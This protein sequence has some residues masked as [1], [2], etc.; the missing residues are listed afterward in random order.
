MKIDM[1]FDTAN[2]EK[3]FELSAKQIAYASV[4]AINRT[5]KELQKE[6]QANARNRLHLRGGS[7]EQL[8]LRSVAKIFQFASV[9]KG[10]PYAEI[11]IDTGKRL[12]L[13]GLELGGSK[14]PF[15]GS[16]VAVPLTG[17]AARPSMGASVPGNLHISN[18][19]L[20]PPLTAAQ[21]KQRQSIKGTNAK[22]TRSM[23]AQFTR[24]QGAGSVWKGRDRTFMIDRGGDTKGIFQRTGP[25][26][27]DFRLI[28]K[29][30]P[31]PALKPMLGF[32]K[33]AITDGDPRLARNLED[34]VR[35]A[36]IHNA[37]KG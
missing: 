12:V 22:E 23:R 13:T 29:F 1:K 26:K 7:G 25:G 2:A 5:A 4:N 30:V 24:A 3:R 35:K 27:S 19:G 31:H 28:Y 36:V 18:L 34:E 8:I 17:S 10:T 14:Q 15:I 9:N 37:G 32:R 16:R 6:E 11:G 33:L 20:Q 21:R